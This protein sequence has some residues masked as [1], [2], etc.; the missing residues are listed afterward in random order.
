MDVSNAFLQGNLLEEV[1]MTL[2]QGFQTPKGFNVQ[3]EKPVCKLIKSLYGLK[4]APRQWNVKL[5]EALLNLGFVQSHLDYSL[6]IKRIDKSL[7]V[8]LVYVDD[9]MITGND[10][11]LIKDTKGI[12]LNTFKMKDLGDLRYFFGIEFARSQEGI[13]YQKT[14][15]PVVKMV[16][17]EVY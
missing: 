17:I 16:T 13:D 2:P 12:L 6:F 1:Y 9:M 4:Q 10:L 7:V 14:F 8:I 15:S 3:G 5:T 11:S